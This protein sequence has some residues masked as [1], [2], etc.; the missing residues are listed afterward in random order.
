M[1]LFSSHLATSYILKSHSLLSNSV[2]PFTHKGAK[3]ASCQKL[4]ALV[5]VKIPEFQTLP[6][7]KAFLLQEHDPSASEHAQKKNT[8]LAGQTWTYTLCEWLSNNAAYFS[9]SSNK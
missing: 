2:S 7:K 9:L 1:L 5:H 6:G 8:D 4:E 3:A